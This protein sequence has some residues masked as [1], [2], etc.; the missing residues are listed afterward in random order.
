MRGEDNKNKNPKFIIRNLKRFSF[1]K[2]NINKQE[3][4]LSAELKIE[5]KIIKFQGFDINKTNLKSFMIT[6]KSDKVQSLKVLPMISDD[7]TFLF[8][9]KQA[10][11]I[12]QTLEVKIV[13]LPKSFIYHYTFIRVLFGE[14]QIIIPIHAYPVMNRKDSNIFP[15]MIDFGIKEIGKEHI[16]K[17][18]L[19]NCV[20][21]NFDFEFK[22]VKSSKNIMIIPR[23]GIIPGNS[24]IEISIIFSPKV[25][26]T[27]VSEA[28]VS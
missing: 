13:L 14:S 4:Q 22:Y 16:I 17:K 1:D 25:A 7:F 10:I 23:K 3:S 8:E 19:Q 18:R 21:I 12:G 15:K 11:G 27:V 9:K 26:S 5:P 6:N 20:S 24:Y 2:Q 28:E